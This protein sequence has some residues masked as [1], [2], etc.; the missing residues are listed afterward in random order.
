M[1][2][3]IITVTLLITVFI[4]CN[5]QK[6]ISSDDSRGKVINASDINKNIQNGKDIIYQ[7]ATIMGT[8][9][10]TKSKNADLV[11]ANL[12]KHDVNSVLTFYDCT[13]KGKI[14]AHKKDKEFKIISD[15]NKSI[16]FV[17]CTFQDTVDFSDSDFKDVVTFSNSIFQNFVSFKSAF[18]SPKG[19]DFTKSHFIKYAEFN[20]MHVSGNCNFFDAVFDDNVLFQLSE[21]NNS[22][23]FNA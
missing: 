2:T 18:F 8:V 16:C 13:F 15:F 12:I 5:K 9:D 4:S 11:N 20:M 17:N 10:F 1:R 21:F 23:Q 14:I 7:N 19:M 3:T 6:K 22:V